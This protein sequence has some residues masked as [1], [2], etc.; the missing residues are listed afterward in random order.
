MKVFWIILIL[1]GLSSESHALWIK[2]SGVLNG[3]LISKGEAWIEVKEDNLSVSRYLAPW[4]GQSPARGGGFDQKLLADIKDLIVGNR[5]KMALFWDGHLRVKKIQHIKPR[6]KSGVF[7]G[8]LIQKGDKWIDVESEKDNTPWRFYAEWVGGLP[9]DGGSYKTSTLQYF[10]NF[11]ISDQVRF[12]WN[13]DHRPRINR[14]I[15]QEDDTF[16]PFYEGE[17]VQGSD[18]KQGLN[19]NSE[20]SFDN[21]QSAPN[22]F[23]QLPLKSPFDQVNP[24]D[25][26]SDGTTNPFD[27]LPKQD[28]NPFEEIDKKSPSDGPNPGLNPFEN[29]PSGKEEVETNPFEDVPLPGN[30]F[31]AVQK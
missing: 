15:E 24:F 2:K 29:L 12:H 11:K 20:N 25:Q 9:E 27:V 10:N 1:V 13:Y 22:P 23:D 21:L 5:V 19:E 17:P 6:K 16:V 7:Y 30:P 14:F 3:I 8:T 28:V 18:V 4:M 26:V 31:D